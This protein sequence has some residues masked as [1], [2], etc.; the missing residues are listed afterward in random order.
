MSRTILVAYDGS[1][2]AQQALEYALETFT[3][4]RIVLFH[5]I[6]PFARVT[7]DDDTELTPL[8]EAWLEDRRDAAE[9]LLEQAIDGVETGDAQVEID[10]GVGSPPQTIVAAAAEIDIDG[11]VL[12]TRGRTGAGGAQLGSAADT[13]VKRANVPVTVVR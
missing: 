7:E 4:E 10:T 1:E 13:V 6:D 8:S 12:G 11:I 9:E 5:A 2:H 3:G